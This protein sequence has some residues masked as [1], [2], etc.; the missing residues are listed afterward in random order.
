M[1]RLIALDVDGTLLDSHHQLSDINA[2]AVIGAHKSGIH[3]VL[4]T[5]KQY[6]GIVPL[7]ER[8][9]LTAPQITSHGALVTDPATGTPQYE[10][11]IPFAAGHRAIALGQEMGVT[12]VVAGHGKTWSTA[13]NRDID[14]MLTY[15]D[16]IPIILDDLTQ[17]L[18]PPPTHL[19]ALAYQQNAL[20][21][22]AYQ[23]FAAELDGQLNVYRSSPYYVEFLHLAASKGHALA[24]ICDRLGIAPDEVVAVGD[25]FNDVSMFGY[26]GLSVAMGNSREEV[27]RNADQIVPGQR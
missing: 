18:D 17:A 26:A 13:R 1:Y 15:G 12:M 21:E 11:G 6:V 4:A 27:K 2:Q 3:I 23:R 22:T 10:Q 14:Y 5:G 16:P 7:I 8:L 25:S 20:Y 19:I 9:G 24:H